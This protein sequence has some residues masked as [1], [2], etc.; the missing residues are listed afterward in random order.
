MDRFLKAL[1]IFKIISN[2]ATAIAG[3]PAMFLNE[4]V[5]FANTQIDSLITQGH[6]PTDFKSDLGTLVADVA[7]IHPSVNNGTAPTPSKG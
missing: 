4:A 3:Q 1:S 6:L 2:V 5:G 7:A